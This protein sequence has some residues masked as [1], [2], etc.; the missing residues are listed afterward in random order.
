MNINKTI[1]MSND[2]VKAPTSAFGGLFR[3]MLANIDKKEVGLWQK[4][5][6]WP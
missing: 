6:N 5:R 2:Y 3:V 1:Q 4:T